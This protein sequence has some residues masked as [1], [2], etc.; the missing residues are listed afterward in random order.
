MFDAAISGSTISLTDT[1]GALTI[2]DDLYINGDID[3]N[4][5]LDITVAMTNDGDSVIKVSNTAVHLNGLAI[6]DGYHT[7][8]GGSIYADNADLTLT[9]CLV[10][11]NGAGNVKTGALYGGGGIFSSDGTLKIY[12]SQIS[13]NTAYNNGGGIVKRNGSLIVGNTTISGNTATYGYGGGIYNYD[14]S[15]EM[16]ASTISNND[17]TQGSGGGISNYKGS[18]QDEGS[19][20]SYNTAVYGYGGALKP[21]TAP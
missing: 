18:F 10:R 19:T 5:T 6:E 7:F 9:N 3:G 4:G 20:I 16:T 12:D 11:N 14:G 17:A 2:D 21:T 1:Y 13:G 8:S 15:V